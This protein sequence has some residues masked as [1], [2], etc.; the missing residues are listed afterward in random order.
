[1]DNVLPVDIALAHYNDLLKVKPKNLRTKYPF[2]VMDES[3]IIKTMKRIELVYKNI[4]PNTS[5]LVNK[6][7]KKPNKTIGAGKKIITIFTM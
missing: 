4:S 2:I 6:N 3:C 1:M 7:S 5:L